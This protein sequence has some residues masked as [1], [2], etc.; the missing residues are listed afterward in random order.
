[1]YVIGAHREKDVEASMDQERAGFVVRLRAKGSVR[2]AYASLRARPERYETLAFPPADRRP[3][4]VTAYE[5]AMVRR[6]GTLAFDVGFAAYLDGRLDAAIEFFRTA[7]RLAPD[8]APS[9]KNL[10]SL[11]L[12]R[13]V[14][15][16]GAA[17]EGARLLET[18]LKMRPEDLEAPS[19]RTAIAQA[20]G[21]AR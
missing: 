7:I 19:I 1:V 11:L 15:S 17:E 10:G 14:A 3:P 5:A 2:D 12:T 8:L 13:P 21:T 16:P 18:Y 9:Y 4:L 6:Y 20:R